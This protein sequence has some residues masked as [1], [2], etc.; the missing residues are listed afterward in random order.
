MKE[1][2]D[3]RSGLL[4][5]RWRGRLHALVLPLLLPAGWL[6]LAQRQSESSRVAVSVFLGG[7]LLCFGISALYHRAARTARTQAL[8]RRLDHGA[9]FLL[10]AGTFTPFAV[11]G[12]EP[13]LVTPVLVGC[14]GLALLGFLLKV[15]DRAWHLGTA[16]YLVLGWSALPLLPFLDTRAGIA[17]G[18]LFIVGGAVYT[19]GAVLFLTHRPR[20]RSE[21]FGFHEFWHLATVLGSA[22]H[23]SAISVLVLR[24]G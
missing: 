8:F 7:L 13:R 2:L 11:L 3:H 6:L 5:P 23:F 22:T 16:L 14:W 4:R 10:V 9:I 18:V 1:N 15:T 24:L 19:V 17:V 20:P 21:V 12:L